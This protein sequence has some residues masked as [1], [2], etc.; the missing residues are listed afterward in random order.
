MLGMMMAGLLMSY[1]PEPEHD[2]YD[3]SSS[4][5]AYSNDNDQTVNYGSKSGSSPPTDWDN[6]PGT[7]TR[8]PTEKNDSRWGGS[9]NWRPHVDDDNGWRPD[10]SHLPGKS[11]KSGT[12]APA[13]NNF[14]SCAM[15]GSGWWCCTTTTTIKNHV[16]ILK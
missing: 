8:R 1:G 6:K 2:D 3:S 10:Q 5:D 11:G 14:E 12:L 15:R 4:N 13:E 16:E 7:P 9:G